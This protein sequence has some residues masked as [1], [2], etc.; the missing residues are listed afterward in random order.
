MNSGQLSSFW[1]Q[2][3]TKLWKFIRECQL[4]MVPTFHKE[5]T[6][7][8]HKWT[9]I[10]N[11]RK[12]RHKKQTQRSSVERV[13]L[14]HDNARPHT[15]AQT[16]QTINNLGWEL[17]PHLPYS[18]D[19]APSDFYLFGPLKEFTIGTKFESDDKVKSVESDWLSHQS[20]DFYGE[21]IRKL[22]DRWENCV[23]EGRLCW[24]KIKLLSKL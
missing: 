19:L 8:K 21:G 12:K 3:G 18:P 1:L 11:K 17:L 24:K 7:N 13:I 9:N 20:K 6:K 15:A 16:V 2:K 22:A 14:H 23:I 10:K 5:Q 4:C